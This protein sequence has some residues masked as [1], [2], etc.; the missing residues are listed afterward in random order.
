MRTNLLLAAIVAENKNRCR[1][2]QL[3]LLWNQAPET[4]YG[5]WREDSKVIRKT[6][7]TAKPRNKRKTEA[8]KRFVSRQYRA[9]RPS[10]L[11]NGQLQIRS[12]ALAAHADMLRDRKLTASQAA[13]DKGVRIRDFWKYVPKAFKKDSKGRIRAIP[14]QYVRRL[15]IPGPDGPFL[16]KIRGSKARSEVARFRNDF[17][18]FLRGDASALD[19]WKGVKI[20]G[21]ELL[22]DPGIIRRLGEQEN[23]PEHFGSEQ[24]IPYSGGAK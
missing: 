18:H 10:S 9:P 2:R 3:A 1:P 7:G 6:R 12:D 4:A 22:T 8:E 14:D 21:H 13:R 11:S 20:Q 17:F 24:A 16:I 15:E 23:L 19:K 5:N